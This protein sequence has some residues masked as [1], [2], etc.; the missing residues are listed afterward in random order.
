MS[1]VATVSSAN[2]WRRLSLF[3]VTILLLTAFSAQPAAACPDCSGHSGRLLMTC[4]SWEYSP[5]PCLVRVMVFVDC[6]TGE[7][8]FEDPIGTFC[9]FP[10]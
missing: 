1:F 10:F 7:V 2:P 8:L 9:V 6:A 4:Y 3:L 5:W